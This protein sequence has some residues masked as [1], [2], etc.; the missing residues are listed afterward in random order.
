[1]AH[2][3]QISRG[4]MIK[5][6]FERRLRAPLLILFLLTASCAAQPK[7]DRAPATP[8]RAAKTKLVPEH[9]PESARMLIS[10][11]MHEHGDSMNVLLWAILFL[12]YE[13]IEAIATD[14]ASAPRL[15]RLPP[16]AGAQL[17]EAFFALQAELA[18]RAHKLADVAAQPVREGEAVAA[19]FGQLAETCVRCHS[20]YLTEGP[21]PVSMLGW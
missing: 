12:D 8:A 6:S 2:R 16:E 18:E 19:A 5:P 9:L 1:M 17:P 20:A 11:R 21:A 4:Q 14:I 7:S 13:S 10:E 3:V 15:E